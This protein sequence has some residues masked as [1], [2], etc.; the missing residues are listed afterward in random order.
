MWKYSDTVG[1]SCLVVEFF[2]SIPSATINLIRW[3]CFRAVANGISG[4]IPNDADPFLPLSVYL[5]SHFLRP[6][7][8][9]NILKP[10]N[11][12]HEYS[13]SVERESGSL[14]GKLAILVVVNLKRFSIKEI[15][16]I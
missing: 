4:K 11:S 8:P 16:Y 14:G 9:T 6:F 2:G 13:A 5:T 10:D 7:L 3:T 15:T 12:E 1:I